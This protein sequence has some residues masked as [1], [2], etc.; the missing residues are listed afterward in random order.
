MRL[1]GNPSLTIITVSH[2]S[3]DSIVGFVSSFLKQHVEPRFK[4]EIDLIFIE[5]SD[6]RRITEFIAPLQRAGFQVKLIFTENKGFGSACN[7][8]AAEASGRVLVFVNPDLT[9]ETS[10]EPLIQYPIAGSWGTV[11]QR[12][13]NGKN[14]S[15]D[16]LPEHKGLFFEIIKGMH[17]VNLAPSLFINKCYVIG[18]FFWVDKDL[19]NVVGRFNERFF[20]YYEEAELSRRLNSHS[21]PVVLGEIRVNHEGFGS[22]EGVLKAKNHQWDG[23]VEYCNITGQ[24]HVFYRTLRTLGFLARF[25]ASAAYSLSVLSAKEPQIGKRDEVTP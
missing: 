15:L 5:N 12:N 16:L 25:S 2:N 9:F 19:F 3:A 24:P 23:L 18:S 1:L 14:Y 10:I 11:R 22:H 13:G 20:L 6:D 21:N 17:F 4:D 7:V 8:G